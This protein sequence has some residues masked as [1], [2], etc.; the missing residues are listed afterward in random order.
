ML[1]LRKPHV[2]P[3]ISTQIVSDHAMTGALAV[4]YDLGP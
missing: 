4:S 2:Q 3:H 1:I